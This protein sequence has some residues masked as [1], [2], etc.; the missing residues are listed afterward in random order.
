MTGVT[1]LKDKIIPVDILFLRR[2][3]CA[4]LAEASPPA[5]DL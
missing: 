1:L 3:G 4:E 5:T 2:G